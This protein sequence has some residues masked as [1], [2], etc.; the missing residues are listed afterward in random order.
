MDDRNLALEVVR[1]T[2]AAALASARL[3]GRG[4]RNAADAVSV[5]AMRRAFDHIDVRGT[6]V[7]GEGERDEAPMLYIGERVGKGWGPPQRKEASLGDAPSRGLS[8]ESRGEGDE[9]SPRVDIAVDPLEGTNLCATGAPDAISVIAIA[10]DGQ[11][12]NAPDT[13]ME[14]IAVGPEARGVIDLRESWTWNLERIARAKQMEVEDLTVIILDR[15]RHTELIGEVRQAGVRIRLIGDGDVS[16]AIATCKIETGIDALFGTGGAPEGVIAAAALRC[17]GGDMQ[18]RLRFRSEAERQRA[19][20][21]G[22]PEESHIYTL[23]ELAAG[24]VMFAATGVTHGSFL[25][26]VHFFSGGATTQSV[27]MRSK[28]GTV[29][30]IDSTHRFDTKPRYSWVTGLDR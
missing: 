30:V 26:G 21:M 3:M 1:V 16:A 22:V 27:V 8:T 10:D 13:Y 29:R 5:E 19:Y 20:S 11:F 14:K 6:V 12:L 7:I 28:S 9:E 4:D 17:V 2:E 25:S 18:G 24:N 23:E 15:D